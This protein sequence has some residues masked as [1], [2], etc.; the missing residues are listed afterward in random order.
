MESP[1]Q[2]EVVGTTRITRDLLLYTLTLIVMASFGPIVLTF[3]YSR[4]PEELVLTSLGKLILPI[5][6][7]FA[8]GALVSLTLARRITMPVIQKIQRQFHTLGY[9]EDNQRSLFSNFGFNL[10]L[11]VIIA[12][13][14]IGS[15]LCQEWSLEATTIHVSHSIMNNLRCQVWGDSIGAFIAGIGMVGFLWIFFQVRLVEKETK[16]IIFVHHYKTLR[17]PTSILLFWL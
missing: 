17:V 16:Q 9:V 12:F 4:I 13:S 8:M 7:T 3:Q 14:T 11:G 2:K 15:Y 5:F 1:D 6:G 10:M